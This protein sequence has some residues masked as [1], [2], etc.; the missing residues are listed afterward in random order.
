VDFVWQ[1]DSFEPLT[2]KPAQITRSN[3]LGAVRTE[4]TGYDN[5]IAKWVLGQVTTV[6]EA[7]TG[8]VMVANSYNGSSAVLESVSKFGKPQ[9]SMTYNPDGT[10]AT[11]SDGLG[12]TTSFSNYK[13]GIAQN[14]VSIRPPHLSAEAISP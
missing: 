14:A 7:N 10:L 9:Q 5:N 11:R 12:H 4:T 2:A 1:A 8:K 3:T 6:T 13:R